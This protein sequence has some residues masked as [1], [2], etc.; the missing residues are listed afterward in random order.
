[1]RYR[2]SI[3]YDMRAPDFGA[4][5]VDLYQAALD[6]IEWADRVGIQSVI[7][8]EHHATTDGYLPSP[9]VMAAAAAARTRS[10]G[11]VISLMLL[12]L[13]HPLR[14]AEDL[15]VL[16]LLSNGRLVVMVGAGY[17][18]A[19]YRQFGLSIKKRP[20]MME[21][22][23]ETLKKA[24]TGEPFE[25]R[26]ETV[27]ILPRPA[28]SPR[29]PIIMG[30]SSNAA[31]ARA[32]RIADGFMPTNPK[33]YEAYREELGRLGKPAPPPMPA[34]EGPAVMF[35]HVAEDPDAAWKLIAPHALH[36]SNEYGRWG[37]GLG[38]PYPEV[39][40]AEALREMGVY[41]VL[42]PA[43]AVEHARRTGGFSLKPLMGGLDP[44]VGWAS[45]KL[46]EREVLPQ[47]QADG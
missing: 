42:T 2:L 47:L 25:F 33:Y 19:E 22:G 46:F 34:P 27:R 35:T 30:G 6:Q 5:P 12:P 36:E 26:G 31:A 23:I 3:A 15:A 11:I 13:Y 32:A 9:I 20:S 21:E 45:L 16:D 29:P 44:A 8:M 37:R 24:W 1:M 18:E 4:R 10:I 17:R 28:Q 39:S 43:Q 7:I 14:A 40:D 41:Q 38:M